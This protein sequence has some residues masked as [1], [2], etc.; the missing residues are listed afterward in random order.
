MSSEAPIVEQPPKD[1][2]TE[3][4]PNPPSPIC[5]VKLNSSLGVILG[6][7]VP[8]QYQVPLK[9]VVVTAYNE[10]CAFIT[11]V[12]YDVEKETPEDTVKLIVQ[13]KRHDMVLLNIQDFFA[14]V[15]PE[16]TAQ[17]P[18]TIEEGS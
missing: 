12:A 10:Q 1:A 6:V 16:S 15:V 9:D 7:C 2:E 14:P 13:N 17:K 4:T 5:Y 3:T 18:D 8:N 11:I